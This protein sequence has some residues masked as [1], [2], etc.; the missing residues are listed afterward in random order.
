MY[1]LFIGFLLR[2][3]QRT[4]FRAS[5]VLKVQ[6]KIKKPLVLLPPLWLIERNWWNTHKKCRDIQKWNDIHRVFSMSTRIFGVYVYHATDYL[7]LSLQF[8]QTINHTY[9]AYIGKCMRML[10]LPR[11]VKRFINEPNRNKKENRN[12]YAPFIFFNL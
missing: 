1:I 9:I 5:I 11:T 7:F 3:V 4:L 2:P 12:I 8:C 6:N 10:E